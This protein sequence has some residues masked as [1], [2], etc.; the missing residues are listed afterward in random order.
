M[1]RVA[2]KIRVIGGRLREADEFIRDLYL[3]PSQYLAVNS[4]DSFRGTRDG[5]VILVGSFESRL[6]YD[7][8]M[9]ELRIRNISVLGKIRDW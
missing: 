1:S 6:D 2:D 3:P 5:A 9:T 7:E 8:L 4:V